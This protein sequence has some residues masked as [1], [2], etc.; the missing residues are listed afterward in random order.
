MGHTKG[1]DTMTRYI[2]DFRVMTRRFNTGSLTAYFS[3]E[4]EPLT[5]LAEVFAAI[6]ENHPAETDNC[7]PQVSGGVFRCLRLEEDEGTHRDVTEDVLEAFRKH[8]EA[9]AGEEPWWLRTAADRHGDKFWDEAA[10]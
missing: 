6:R 10:A 3:P 5:T 8:V 4:S 7:S 2:T 9:E 1:D